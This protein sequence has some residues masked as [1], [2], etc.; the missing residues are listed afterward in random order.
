MSSFLTVQLAMLIGASSAA[1][2]ATLKAPGPSALP[3]P[4]TEYVG[5]GYT[6]S[7]TEFRGE[8][9]NEN[10]RGRLRRCRAGD[11]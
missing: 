2:G 7:A 6:C 9:N 3:A 5:K 1:K 4:W 10:G 8:V 11:A